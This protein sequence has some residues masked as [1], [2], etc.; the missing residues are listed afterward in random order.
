M[1]AAPTPVNTEFVFNEVGKLVGTISG[2][3]HVA[4]TVEIIA[5]SGEKSGQLD[6]FTRYTVAESS[7]QWLPIPTCPGEFGWVLD[8]SVPLTATEHVHPEDFEPSALDRQV[9]GNHYKDCRIQPIEYIVA[10]QLNFLEGSVVKRVT[11]HDHETGKGR[12]DIEKA[13]HELQL[14]LELVY[15]E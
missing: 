6:L 9:G 4:K 2:C 1:I 15:D 8:A 12:Q 7:L 13:I 5:K 14:L 3:N 10:N 11:R